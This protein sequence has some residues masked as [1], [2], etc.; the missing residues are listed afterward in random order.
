MR[1]KTK[2]IKIG[3][4]QCRI[5][6]L[7]ACGASWI[8]GVLMAVV[9]DQRRRQAQS[10]APT[11]PSDVST[12]EPPPTDAAARED[13]ARGVVGA[14]WLTAGSALDR[15]RYRDVQQGC[16]R[17]CTAQNDGGLFEP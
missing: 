15:D 5:A 16:L 1:P 10:T 2:D 13:M 4:Y 17:V 8:L 3:D 11:A 9:A 12:P 14:L 7:D 6:K